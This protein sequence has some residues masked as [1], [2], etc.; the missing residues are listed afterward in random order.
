VRG[1]TFQVTASAQC[2]K[3]VDCA[4]GELKLLMP[5]DMSESKREGDRDKGWQI[6]VAVGD[7]DPPSATEKILGASLASATWNQL[8]PEAPALVAV[9]Q[10]VTIAGYALE[11]REPVTHI[12]AT[13]THISPQTVRVAPPYTLEVEPKG[14]IEVL[15]KKGEPFDVL[16][17]IHSYATKGAV[18]RAGLTVPAGWTMSSP[19]EIAFDGAGDR[20]VKMNVPPPK[21]IV[22]GD[23]AVTAYASRGG[24]GFAT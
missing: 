17:R 19:Q 8:L 20:Y 16:L 12:E 5:K 9:S 7:A 6:T 1:E 15:G 22:T 21:Q 3:E 13:S 14:A 24:E 4:L 10:K 23:C 18:G 2:R 11:V